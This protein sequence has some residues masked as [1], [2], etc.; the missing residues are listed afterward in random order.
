MVCNRKYLF[1]QILLIM[2]VG[3]G[4]EYRFPLSSDHPA[5]FKTHH[6][7]HPESNSA[8]DINGIEIDV[9]LWRAAANSQESVVVDMVNTIWDYIGWTTEDMVLPEA[10]KI[11]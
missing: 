4:G 6:W 7:Q 10:I 1:T 8:I 2:T 11:S 3:L 5:A 9:F